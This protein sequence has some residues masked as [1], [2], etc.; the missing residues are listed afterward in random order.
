MKAYFFSSQSE[1]EEGPSGRTNLYPHSL[2]WYCC[3]YTC[4][5]PML[6]T[7]HRFVGISLFSFIRRCRVNLSVPRNREINVFYLF[8]YLLTPREDWSSFYIPSETSLY[9]LRDD[10]YSIFNERIYLHSIHL[11]DWHLFYLDLPF[12]H[13]RIDLRPSTLPTEEEDLHSIYWENLP[14]LQPLIGW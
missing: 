13:W 2:S 8:I 10:L 12:T 1:R 9:Q 6:L 5:L 11:E 14:P 4:L 7:V 3:L